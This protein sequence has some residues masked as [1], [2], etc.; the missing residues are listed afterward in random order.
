MLGKE[1]EHAGIGIINFEGWF[2]PGIDF[3]WAGSLTYDRQLLSLTFF[4][5][6]E[7]EVGNLV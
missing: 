7:V 5:K 6:G 4:S 1:K 3:A 2:L